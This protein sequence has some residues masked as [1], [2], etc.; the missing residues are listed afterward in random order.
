MKSQAVLTEI[1]FIKY[2]AFLFR[3]MLRYHF[4]LLIEVVLN[5]II[6]CDAYTRVIQVSEKEMKISNCHFSDYNICVIL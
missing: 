4:V 2:N 1:N 5:L 6:L 3:V